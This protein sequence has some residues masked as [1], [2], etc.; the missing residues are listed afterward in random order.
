MRART[1]NTSLWR[2][3]EALLAESGLTR[4]A[5]TA[6]QGFMALIDD[7]DEA[8]RRLSLEA[9]AE[10]VLEASDLL[11]FH[12]KESGEKG[13]ARV[14]NLQELLN[15]TRQFEPDPDEP[16]PLRAFL[17]T[18]ALDA[19]DQ[20]ADEYTDA[21][22]LMPLHSA[23]GLEFPVV[24]LAGVEEN[25]FPHK[26]SLEEPGRL[27]EERRLCYVGITRAM[28]QLYLSYAETRRWYGQ[29]SYNTVSRFVR[30]IPA[31]C[32]K[33]VRINAN[34]SRPL[35]A[36]MSHASD[37]HDTGLLLGQRVIHSVF[38]Q[39]FVLNIEGQGSN[40]RVQ[41]NFDDEGSKWLVAA[42]ANL[43]AL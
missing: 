39:G 15:A 32:L 24:Y 13:L 4:R 7:C 2:A 40:A 20:Q 41:V 10:Y 21:V 34:I 23:K 38:G 9:A 1:D 25:L 26:M 12:G 36:N 6:V 42:Y 29:E 8:C 33:E 18:V 31:N 37:G 3:G 28:R 11:T 5:L 43:E 16:S 22:Q 17:D 30:E 19:G 35:S 14:E 27:E